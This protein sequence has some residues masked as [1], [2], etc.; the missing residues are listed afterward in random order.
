VAMQAWM[1]RSIGSGT[2]SDRTFWIPA[3]KA[4]HLHKGA[5]A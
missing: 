2:A 5:I 4:H 1:I 3:L